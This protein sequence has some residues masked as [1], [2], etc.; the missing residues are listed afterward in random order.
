MRDFVAS[1]P[2]L[3]YMLKGALQAKMKGQEMAEMHKEIKNS[4]K[5][6]CR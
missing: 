4:G 6:T 5:D 1:S 3:Q 2:A